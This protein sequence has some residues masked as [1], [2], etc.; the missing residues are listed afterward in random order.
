MVDGTALWFGAA[1]FEVLG[2]VDDGGELVVEVQTMAQL[3]GCGSCGTKAVPK[4]RR[5]V[6]LRDTPL[7]ARPVRVR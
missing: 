1:E 7:G 4:D 2:V 5:W 3:T 6:T